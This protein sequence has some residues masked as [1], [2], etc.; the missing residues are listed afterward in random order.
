MQD[1]TK[2]ASILI[3]DDQESNIRLLESILRRAG[4]ANLRST[5]DPREVLSLQAD[6]Q[7][8][9]ILLDLH[10][11]HRDGFAVMEEFNAVLPAGSY[12]PILVL[13]ADITPE[14]KRRALMLG[15][16]DFLT[17]PFDPT[18]VLLRIRTLLE[19]RALHRALENQNQI[20]DD[21]VRERTQELEG[22][23][24]EALQYARRLVDAQETERRV[25]AGELHDEI[26]QTLTGL[27]ILLEIAARP[28]TGEAGVTMSTARSLVDD[29]LERV[30]TLLLNLKPAVLDDL[31]LVPAVL[32][33]CDRYTAQTNV[34]VAVTH[35]GV[36]GRR[37]GGEVEIAAYR[38]VQE[39]L[40][41]VA[42]HAGVNAATVRLW[43]NEGTLG[44]QIEDMGAGFDP[45]ATRAGTHSNGLTGMRERALGA[46]GR[47]T[48]ESQAGCG[49]RVTAELPC[50]QACSGARS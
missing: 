39:A 26:G 2:R 44:V 37:F 21:E 30:R 25:I 27:K 17:K 40:T 10:M 19:T 7:P 32:V 6:A 33:H 48:V 47:L 11:P 20:L 41:N 13:T 31:G 1:A 16:K 9:L 18:E 24:A 50:G 14:A 35:A 42:R 22:A 8:D 46:G 34:R 38:I 4:Y 43:A 49:T 5:T 23:R 12:L 15:A 28:L 36:E 45:A 29:L 3:V